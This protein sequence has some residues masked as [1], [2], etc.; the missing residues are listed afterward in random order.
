[1]TVQ[2]G[3]NSGNGRTDSESRV[4][5]EAGMEQETRERIR[6]YN[7]KGILEKSGGGFHSPL[8]FVV[9]NLFYTVWSGRYLCSSL[10]SV[11]R[12]YLDFYS[13]IY[14]MEG[15]ME[16]EYEGRLMT[17]GENEAVLLD[18]RKPHAYRAASA[19]LD[20]WEMIFNGNAARDYYDLLTETRGHIFTVSG[21][22]KRTF[23][24]LMAELEAPYPKD[25]MVSSLI[26]KMLGCMAEQ[27]E[28]SVSPV[29]AEAMTYI[30]EHYGTQLQISEIA[31]HVMLSRYY[32]TR[33][34][35]RETGRSPNEYLADVRIDSAREMLTEKI[36]P[37]AEI[38]ERCGFTNT[39]HFTRFF[40]EKTGQTPAA[41]RKSFEV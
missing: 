22:L 6:I 29:I 39:S 21:T 5:T 41:F 15:R 4:E 32:F 37:I 33:L 20:K 25:H 31:E 2:K 7:E 16:L 35:R 40:R 13:V 11:R 12:E 1:M 23:T 34:F 14:V 26:H 24:K 28:A 8:E 17:V 36:L 19:R 9:R 18:F 30:N 3:N 38:A 27:E 10:Y